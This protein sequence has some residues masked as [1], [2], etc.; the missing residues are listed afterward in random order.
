ML[1]GNVEDKW[2]ISMTENYTIR[3]NIPTIGLDLEVTCTDRTLLL[4][5]DDII[6]QTVIDHYGLKE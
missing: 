4:K 1:T 6:R 2:C 3:K 5:L